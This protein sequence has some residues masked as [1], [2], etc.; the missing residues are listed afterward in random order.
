MHASE[1]FHSS[2]TGQKGLELPNLHHLVGPGAS[3]I[4]THI[5]SKGESANMVKSG[6]L[7]DVLLQD[8]KHP[9]KK[10]AP[11]K[12]D[13]PKKDA[14]HSTTHSG[15]HGPNLKNV[16]ITKKQGEIAT[17]VVTSFIP[18]GGLVKLAAP[19]AV[20]GVKDLIHKQQQKNHDHAHDDKKHSDK[21][22]DQKKS[23]KNSSHPDDP[24]YK[25]KHEGKNGLIHKALKKFHL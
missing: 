4:E 10:D 22:A 6:V 9:K 21:P 7:P 15:A 2:E 18:G 5:N 11:Q 25:L 12:D 14:H 19:Y 1:N 16:H 3:A 23:E 17:D 20:K 24:L 8:D 13:P